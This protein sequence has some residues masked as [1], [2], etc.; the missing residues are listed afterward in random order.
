MILTK[1]KIYFA[2]DFHLGIDPKIPAPERFPI[3]ESLHMHGF[4]I[5]NNHMITEEDW[6]KL[7]T[8]LE[9]YGR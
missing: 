7:E 4:F 9:T 2:S 5:G 3:A 1:D 8:L 6:I